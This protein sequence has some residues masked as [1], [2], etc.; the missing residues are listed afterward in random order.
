M[1]FLALLSVHAYSIPFYIIWL[2][3]IVYAVL[4][5]QRHPRTSWFAAIALG[6]RLCH[7]TVHPGVDLAF[8]G[9]FQAGKYPGA[10]GGN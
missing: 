9:D 8:G 5:R 2:V 7:S 6:I 1:E 10:R 4:N 3:G